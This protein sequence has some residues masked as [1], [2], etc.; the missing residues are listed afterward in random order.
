[1]SIE[2]VVNE[3]ALQACFICVC[4]SKFF[5]LKM[6]ENDKHMYLHMCCVLIIHEQYACTVEKYANVVGCKNTD[7]KVMIYDHT[8]TVYNL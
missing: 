6:I 8:C 5:L 3:R 1:M 4:R 7:Y 2:I